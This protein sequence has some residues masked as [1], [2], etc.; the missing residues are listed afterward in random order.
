MVDTRSL[1]AA[2]RPDC[3]IIPSRKTTI[4]SIGTEMSTMPQPLHDCNVT[5]ACR[6]SRP[7]GQYGR[8]GCCVCIRLLQRQECLQTSA[9]ASCVLAKEAY[10]SGDM[11]GA[12]SGTLLAALLFSIVSIQSFRMHQGPAIDG[13]SLVSRREGAPKFPTRGQALGAH[14]VSSQGPTVDAGGQAEV[15]VA[16]GTNK[17]TTGGERK[18]LGDG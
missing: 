17:L 1:T 18:L 12:Y 14:T 7:N 5:K 9:Q 15:C 13:Q 4:R 11:H 2:C 8:R 3:D 16:C 10:R 6:P